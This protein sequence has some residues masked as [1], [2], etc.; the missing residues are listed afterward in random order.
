MRIDRRRFFGWMAA[1]FGAVTM[2]AAAWARGTAGFARLVG[3]QEEK[4]MWG[5]IVK[6]TTVTG[7]RDEMIGVLKGSAANMPGCLSYVVAKDAADE[8]ILWV[9]EVWDSEESHDA[10]LSL[11]AVKDAI[12]RGKELVANYERIATTAPVWGVGLPAAAAR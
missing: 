7:K 11:P 8:N 12:P 1:T 4:A 6:V 9:T 5:M 2:S 3:S 10:A